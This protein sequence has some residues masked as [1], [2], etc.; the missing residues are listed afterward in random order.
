MGHSIL[1]ECSIQVTPKG[2][3]S[4]LFKRELNDRNNRKQERPES[5]E[6]KVHGERRPLLRP[7]RP[8]NLS[9]FQP[10]RRVYPDRLQGHKH[11]A[12]ELKGQAV[13]H[14]QGP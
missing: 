13:A 5:M 2:R 7:H 4:I 14:L 6:P 1:Q 11:Q 12:L 8:D 9:E 3:S 10:Q